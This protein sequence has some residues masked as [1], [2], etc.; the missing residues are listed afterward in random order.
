MHASAHT[1]CTLFTQAA[2]TNASS[3]ALDR[4]HSKF[5]A[6]NLTTKTILLYCYTAILLAPPP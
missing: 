1:N 4:C 3:T 2:T 5:K 6:G